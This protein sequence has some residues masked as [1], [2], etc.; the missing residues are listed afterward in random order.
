MFHRPSD[1]SLAV[2]LHRPI[3]HPQRLVRVAA[4]VTAL[5]V[6]T[7]SCA[8][9]ERPTL[10][11]T[12]TAVGTMTGDAAIDAVLTLFDSVG[13]AVFTADYTAVIAFGSTASSI[14]VTQDG[15]Q[16]PSIRRSVTIGDVRYISTSN[17]SST[18]SVSTSDCS[19]GIDAAR[20]SDTGVT[21]EFVFGDMAKRL[22]RDAMSLVGAATPSTRETPGGPA[23]CVD[24]PVSGGTKQYCVFDDGVLARFVGADVTI[25]ITGRRPTVDESLFV[26]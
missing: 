24:V 14:A 7:A 3:S 25:D 23:S 19:D 10:E 9:G 15:S 12:P 16:S 6:L 5:G 4:A 17:N 21:P 1:A 2:A 22:R 18:C 8:L 11:S 20:V 26:V 13:T